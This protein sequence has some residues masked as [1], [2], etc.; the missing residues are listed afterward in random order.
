MFQS[1]EKA[2][3]GFC[4]KCG[5]TICA[6]DDG[7][8][9]ISITIPMLDTPSEILPDEQHSFQESAPNWWKVSVDPNG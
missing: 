6:I 2:R 4:P 3:R 9:K 8:D 5:G 7:Y 1:S